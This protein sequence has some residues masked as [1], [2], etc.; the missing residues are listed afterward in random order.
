[1]F[2]ESEPKSK[3]I[4]FGVSKKTT[5]TTVAGSFPRG[6]SGKDIESSPYNLNIKLPQWAYASFFAMDR[7]LLD[8]DGFRESVK[9][10]HEYSRWMK[11]SPQLTQ[12]SLIPELIRLGPFAEALYDV[13]T[14]TKAGSVAGDMELGAA[15]VNEIVQEFFDS[16]DRSSY[17]SKSMLLGR[18]VLRTLNVSGSRYINNITFPTFKLLANTSIRKVH[19]A[20]K[21]DL[22]VGLI[23]KSF[24]KYELSS[25]LRK[26]KKKMNKHKFRKLRKRTR[27]LRRRL[28]K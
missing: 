20:R 22:Y 7:P 25:V 14:N 17:G 9:I 11:K 6:I 18:S 27:A 4:G 24:N 28:G 1:M 12:E 26:K 10:S 19:T 21:S 3:K 8:V 15:E 13:R 23:P 2:S 5:K 16:F